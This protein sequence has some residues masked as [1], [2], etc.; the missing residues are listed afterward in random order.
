MRRT[1]RVQLHAPLNL[2]HIGTRAEWQ[3]VAQGQAGKG[4]TLEVR[5]RGLRECSKLVC[6]AVYARLF[7]S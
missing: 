1:E 5:E 2:L 3:D 4:R 6:Q 7:F